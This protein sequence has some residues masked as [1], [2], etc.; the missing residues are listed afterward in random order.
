MAVPRLNY[1]THISDRLSEL[2]VKLKARSRAGL[3]DGAK[4]AEAIVCRLFNELFKWDLVNLNPEQINCPA[5]DLGDSS[6]RI[7]VQVTIED[8]SKKITQT[9]SKIAEH[10][11]G[12][13]CDQVIIFFVLPKKPRLPKGFS[14]SV[15]GVKIEVWDIGD[16]VK[17]A[18]E[19]VELA[20]LKRAAEIVDEELAVPSDVTTKIASSNFEGG[21]QS[22]LSFDHSKYGLSDAAEY[23]YPSFFKIE[24]PGTIQRAN[25]ITKKGVKFGEKL[26]EHWKKLEKKKAPP[27]DFHIE[28]GVIHTFDLLDQPVWKSL[29][30]GRAIEQID[31]IK[32]TSL[33]MSAN[34]ADRNV[35]TKILQRNLEQLCN[36]IGTLFELAYSKELKCYL[37]QAQ[38]GRPSGRIKLPAVSKEGTREVFKEILNT[39][40]G[41]EGEVQHWKHQAFRHRFFTFGGDWYINIVPF[42]AFT[43]DG[44]LSRSKWHDTSSRNVKKPERNRAVLGHI[45]FW[46]ALLCKSPDMFELPTSIRIIRPSKLEV[47]PSVQDDAWKLIASEE[48]K[49]DLV[50]DG[51]EVL[52]LL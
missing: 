31:P 32:S 26:R 45:L 24:Y 3:N 25:I 6:N 8:T 16:V 2:A 10:D 27:V 21:K 7:G 9:T 15:A 13:K 14:K 17:R 33:S 36:N 37:F 48:E 44:K 30:A 39:L 22:D 1:V 34:L 51:E 43:C 18:Q 23:L 40:P 28:N 52:F 42:W 38:T 47:S 20:T 12:G 19:I 41:K 5:I 29:L 35:F 49:I 4:V 46:A 11:L 50:A